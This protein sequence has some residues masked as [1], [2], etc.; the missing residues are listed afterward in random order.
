MSIS[1]KRKI[2]KARR[3]KRRAN[4]KMTAPNL[5]K[6]SKCSELMMPHRVCKK[7]GTYNNKV[8]IENAE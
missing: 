1:P 5:V 2:S 6:C 8:V 7:C 4:W 3:N